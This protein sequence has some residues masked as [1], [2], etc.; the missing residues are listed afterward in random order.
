MTAT[1]WYW[2]KYKFHSTDFE[3]GE[4]GRSQT[5]GGVHTT[6]QGCKLYYKGISVYYIYQIEDN[7]LCSV[8]NDVRIRFRN[9]LLQEVH[10][11]TQ[12]LHVHHYRKTV[13]Y[14]TNLKEKTSFI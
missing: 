9:Q 11:A 4:K 10:L 14:S 13:V 6:E 1:T 2:R 8:R 7:F 12:A 5:F 3:Q